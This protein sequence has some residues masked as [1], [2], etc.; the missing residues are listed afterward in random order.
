M[1][2][3]TLPLAL[4]AGLAAPVQVLA[5]DGISDVLGGVARAMITQELDRNSYNQ[6]R[7]QNTAAAYEQYLAN[8]PQGAHRQEARTAL[9]NLLGRQP[10]VQPPVYQQPQAVNTAASIEANLGLSRR[11][12]TEVQQQLTA[13]GY[14]TRGADGAWGNNTRTA[15]R[16]WQTANGFAASGYVTRQD[17]ALMNS[18]YAALPKAQTA[19]LPGT[20]AVGDEA[21]ER[22]LGLSV[23]ERREVQ[24]R[25]TLLGHQTE[26]TAGSFNADTRRA[27]RA[28]QRSQG[29]PE[30][31]YLTSDQLR[32]LQRQTGG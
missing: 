23:S 30:T 24:L 28:W 12:R 26:G 1:N 29:S 32:A 18:Q 13:L 22:A 27:L 21:A 4:M 20:P 11:E 31:G 14:N 15:I 8:F 5:Q 2:R 9:N 10:A 25:L 6:A 16:N 7:Q 17:L 3:I 19:P